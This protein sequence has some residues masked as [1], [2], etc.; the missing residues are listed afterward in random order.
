MAAHTDSW[1]SASPKITPQID[2]YENLLK[3]AKWRPQQAEEQL[4]QIRERKDIASFSKL[5]PTVE[6]MQEMTKPFPSLGKEIFYMHGYLQEQNKNLAGAAISYQKSADLGLDVAQTEIGTCYWKQIGVKRDIDLAFKYLLLAA[7][8][9]HARGQYNLS[10]LMESGD[11]GRKDL[12]AAL[13]WRQ[14]AAN[15]GNEK[16]KSSLASLLK[17]CEEDAKLY[18]EGYSF[19]KQ[20]NYYEAF[21]AYQASAELGNLAAKDG[22]ARL[23]LNG[24]S[25]KR[26]VNH[27]EQLLRENAQQGHG[28]SIFNLASLLQKKGDLKGARLWY[29]EA[30]KLKIEE[31]EKRLQNL[32]ISTQQES[33][34]ETSSEEQPL[35]G[36]DPVHEMWVKKMGEYRLEPIT[37]NE[38]AMLLGYYMQSP[39]P[40][41]P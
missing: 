16:A 2:S 22:L 12:D 32:D 20:K 27:A 39:V 4:I 3:A 35:W 38:R 25:V 7:R 28:R 33:T 31:A 18:G 34:A 41:K 37:D 5:F 30:A 26:D 6:K 21:K 1:R 19:E 24:W 8:Q 13:F 9:G 15:V 14:S 40:G 17:K 11:S 36:L 10:C 29:E 23:Y